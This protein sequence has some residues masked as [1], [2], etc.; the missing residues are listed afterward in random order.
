M[1]IYKQTLPKEDRETVDHI[2]K[3]HD[4]IAA[5]RRKGK[6]MSMKDRDA[7]ANIY[8]EYGKL[9]GSDME[10]YLLTMYAQMTYKDWGRKNFMDPNNLI[11]NF[12][13]TKSDELSGML[14]PMSGALQTPYYSS[15]EILEKSPAELVKSISVLAKEI[16]KWASKKEHTP[17]KPDFVSKDK[18]KIYNSMNSNTDF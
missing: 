9:T 10:N 5:N 14:Y 11:N 12:A 3:T 18:Q 8:G 16:V 7:L 6:F 13:T 15:S 1:A 2:M 4:I 17:D